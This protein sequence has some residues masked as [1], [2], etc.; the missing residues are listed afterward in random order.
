MFK[1]ARVKRARSLSPMTPLEFKVLSRTA[2][3]P[4]TYEGLAQAL[5]PKMIMSSSRKQDKPLSVAFSSK[6][7]ALGPPRA[8]SPTCI[9]KFKAERFLFH[10][11]KTDLGVQISATVTPLATKS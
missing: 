8:L 7:I 5:C 2:C 1:M 9:T 3:M 6:A 10:L 11:G 4:V